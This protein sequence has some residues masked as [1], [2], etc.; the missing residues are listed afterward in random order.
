MAGVLLDTHALYWLVS[1]LETLSENV[2]LAIGESQ[3]A[4]TLYLSPISAWELSLA[5]KKPNNAPQLGDPTVSKWFAQARRATEA[6]IVSINQRI[7]LEAANVVDDTGHRDPGDCYLIATA[8]V[9]NLTLLS[10]DKAI[11]R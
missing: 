7:A 8:R 2:L 9:R 3:L 5:L 6:K 4:R 11:K 1:G 10:R